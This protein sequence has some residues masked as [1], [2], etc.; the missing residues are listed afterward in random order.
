MRLVSRENK[1]VPSKQ[2]VQNFWWPGQVI[3]ESWRSRIEETAERE[4][5]ARGV[6]TAVRMI[7][8]LRWITRL[9]S[10]LSDLEGS[11]PLQTQAFRGNL[12]TVLYLYKCCIY[13]ES[14]VL[15]QFC[16]PVLKCSNASFLLQNAQQNDTRKSTKFIHLSSFFAARMVEWEKN[17]WMYERWDSV[18]LLLCSRSASSGSIYTENQLNEFAFWSALIYHYLTPILRKPRFFVH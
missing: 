16:Q 14:S 18:Q 8:V 11:T 13:L 3:W 12:G 2:N 1:F 5:Y 15:R 4:V 10:V 17:Q 7:L 6:L 9:I